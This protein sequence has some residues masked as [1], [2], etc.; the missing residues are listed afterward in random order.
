MTKTLSYAAL[1]RWSDAIAFYLTEK[2]M[3]RGSKIGV[4]WQRG[5]ELHAA[6]LGIVK[7][8]ATYIPVD[9]EIPAERVEVI[10]QEVDAT[11]CFSLQQLNVECPHAGSDCQ[12]SRRRKYFKNQPARIQMIVPM[13]CIR[14]AVPVNQR[15]SP[16]A[17][18]QICH[19]VRSEQTVF[20]IQPTD[21]VYQGFS[22]SFDMWCEE[23]WISYFAGATLWVAD[24]TTSKAIDELGE[25][26][27]KEKITILHAVPSLL[28]VIEDT[29]PSLRLV[30]AGRREAC[31]PQVLAKWAKPGRLFYNSYG[32]TETTVTAT[33]APLKAG[34]HIVIGPAIAKL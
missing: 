2:G 16:S 13:C 20:N 29:I 9:R 33:I 28:A 24:N 7:A 21:K 1:D 10:L 14:P 4:W 31:T 25:T 32:P 11:A 26:L 34:D 30:N 22:V 27:L 18:K 12:T 15:V 23:T 6:I 5:F 17:R 19:L 3:G 8:G